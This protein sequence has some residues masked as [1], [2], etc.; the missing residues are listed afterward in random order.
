MFL[1]ILKLRTSSKKKSGS[2]I[3]KRSLK[4]LIVIF[5]IVSKYN[6]NCEKQFTDVRRC[7]RIDLRNVS[8]KIY[9]CRRLVAKTY[10]SKL[11]RAA[12]GCLG[13]RRR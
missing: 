6:K 9:F 2:K 3:A 1:D 13:I 7:L 10:V 5:S 4:V 11:L 8:K 12:G